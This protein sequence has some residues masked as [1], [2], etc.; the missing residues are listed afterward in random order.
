MNMVR[1]GVVDHPSQ[2]PHSGYKE[3]QRP[4]RKNILIDYEKFMELQGADNYDQAK[5]D[6]E[7]WAAELLVNGNGWD[8]KWTKSIAVGNKEFVDKVKSKLGI[9]AQG[10]DAKETDEGYQLREPIEAYSPHLEAKKGDIGP[11]NTYYWN[12]TD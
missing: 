10:R 3:I 4:R 1:A 2:W 8:D 9:L 11:E 7:G 6:H 5:R 12:I